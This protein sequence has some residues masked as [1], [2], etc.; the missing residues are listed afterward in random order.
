MGGMVSGFTRSDFNNE[1]SFANNEKA[2]QVAKQQAVNNE[3]SAAPI[4]KKLQ[5]SKKV[6]NN[7][8]NGTHKETLATG[9]GSFEEICVEEKFNFP[10]VSFFT[11]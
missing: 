11:R 1:N 7:N 6:E 4:E 10:K 3:K 8:S 2:T 9:T 5:E